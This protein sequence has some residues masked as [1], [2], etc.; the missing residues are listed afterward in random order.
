LTER[1]DPWDIPEWHSIRQEAMLIQQLLGSGATALG[2]ANYADKKGVYYTAFFG[3]SVGLER[4]C[5]LVLIVDY[6]LKNQGQMPSQDLV[7]KF[8]HNIVKLMRKAER[9][10]VAHSLSLDYQKPEDSVAK[11]IVTNLDA[12][13]DAQRGRYANFASICDP[14]LTRDEPLSK[15]WNQVAKEILNQRYFG[16]AAQERIENNARV[17]DAMLS[18]YT[19]VQHFSEERE[20][21]DNLETASIRTGQ[22][23]IVQ[24][25]S[26]YHSLTIIRWLS[27]IYSKLAYGAV[28]K[29][30]H[31]A[32][33][34]T[35]E[36]FYTYTVSDNFLKS[37]KIWP[38]NR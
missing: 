19:I 25:W 11:A 16:T 13:A 5:K 30:Q 22:T 2:R 9:V 17:I 15:W 12:F 6:A 3:L 10:S 14:N 21:I 36:F 1:G 35:W 28:C 23:E 24:K 20:Q 29:H 27:G 26:R 8:G 4:L 7:K 32:F 33:F 37:R 18:K 38:L 34:G 31:D